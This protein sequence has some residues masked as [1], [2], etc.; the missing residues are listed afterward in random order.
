MSEF[1]AE[2]FAQRAMD[3]FTTAT[4][5]AEALEATPEADD[6]VRLKELASVEVELS[7]LTDLASRARAF[8]DELVPR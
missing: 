3:L 1:S 4:R 2:K 6:S 8:V 7:E 5:A